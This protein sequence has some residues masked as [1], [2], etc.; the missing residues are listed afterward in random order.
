MRRRQRHGASILRDE[1]LGGNWCLL[2]WL[3]PL[4]PRPHAQV[5]V[6]PPPC[7]PALIGR[8]QE[9]ALQFAFSVKLDRMSKQS[10]LATPVATTRSHQS[11]SGQLL[12][13]SYLFFPGRNTPQTPPSFPGPIDLGER[14]R[15]RSL[16]C[17]SVSVSAFALPLV[18][19]TLVLDFYSLFLDR[20]VTNETPTKTKPI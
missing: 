13:S 18:S 15:A 12:S 4:P 8:L 11:S 20:T 14:V 10:S 19:P 9:R 5:Q 17:V 7:Q 2:L 6:P 3:L 1:A 16:V